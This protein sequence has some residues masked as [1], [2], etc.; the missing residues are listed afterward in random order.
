[1]AIRGI[2]IKMTGRPHPPIAAKKC[3]K[4]VWRVVTTKT[5]QGLPAV[6]VFKKLSGVGKNFSST[7]MIIVTVAGVVVERLT[8]LSAKSAG[9]SKI[10]KFQTNRPVKI[11]FTSIA[12][13]LMRQLMGTDVWIVNI[14][15]TAL[16][17]TATLVHTVTVE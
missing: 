17:P 3:E 7:T 5:V 13:A 8:S 9:T 4:S 12:G 1:M 16:S 14:V 11:H 10:A 6:T 15:N 2:S